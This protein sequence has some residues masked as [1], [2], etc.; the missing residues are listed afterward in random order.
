MNPAHTMCL[1]TS[2]D[3]MNLNCSDYN[4]IPPAALKSTILDKH[5]SLRN[6]YSRHG[7]RKSEFQVP[8]MLALDWDHE[9]ADVAAR[10]AWQ[11]P[12]DEDDFRDVDRFKVAN[13][14]GILSSTL[15]HFPDL[16][17]VW[18][19]L[20]E[21][22]RTFHELRSHRRWEPHGT[23]KSAFRPDEPLT[24]LTNPYF[25]HVGCA[26]ARYQQIVGDVLEHRTILVC[27]YGPLDSPYRSIQPSGPPCSRCP[28]A[29]TCHSNSSYPNLCFE[30]LKVHNHR[31]RPEVLFMNTPNGTDSR[32]AEKQ[33]PEQEYSGGGEYYSGG[34]YGGEGG[35]YQSGDYYDEAFLNFT[36][37]YCDEL[38]NNGEQHTLCKYKG[39]TDEFSEVNSLMGDDMREI[40]L[41]QHNFVRDT[42][43]RGY[44][45][46]VDKEPDSNDLTSTK[47]PLAA[48]MREMQWND[49]LELIAKMWTEQCKPTKDL[50]RDAFLYSDTERTYISQ[51][52][53]VTNWTGRDGDF[54]SVESSFYNW[55]NTYSYFTA[56]K[57]S[58]YTDPKDPEKN[59]K[60][61]AQIIWADSYMIGCA[62][63]MCRN[64]NTTN[65]LIITACNY[66][67]GGV[68]VGRNVY[69]KGGPCTVCHLINRTSM[70]GMFC[71]L[72]FSS[73]CSGTTMPPFIQCI[74][75]VFLSVL[76]FKMAL[77]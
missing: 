7:W 66:G 33:E 14:V 37:R 57:I 26:G 35:E 61:F 11:C 50:C 69:T 75:L 53:D 55:Y 28:S 23:L 60:S 22:N 74:V 6:D 39:P 12:Y 10:W 41:N 38:C 17:N 27:N 16:E 42:F 44:W 73:L 3:S 68:I 64:S 40:I 19:T 2:F 72:E 46:L 62:M 13:T 21:G 63:T 29:T 48:N 34:E 65:S 77:Q 30:N 43:A 54:P 71:S 9:L 8:N 4:Q 70:G 51:L 31:H 58:P 47:L 5:N 67:P 15:H 76:G 59:Y 1:Y 52:I 45:E 25:K 20:I 36:A 18:E 24:L 49:E 56:D 32:S